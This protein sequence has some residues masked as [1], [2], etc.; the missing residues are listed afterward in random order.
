M[1]NKENCLTIFDSKVLSIKQIEEII[2]TTSERVVKS[3][4]I[5]IIENKSNRDLSGL[6]VLMKM[7]EHLE[8]DEIPQLEISNRFSKPKTDEIN[9][10]L[11]TSSL[12]VFSE[13]KSIADNII[14][15]SNLLIQKNNLV[16]FRH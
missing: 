4:S 16:R 6:L 2:L 15:A 10:Y 1:L 12:G 5:I 13:N 7:N 8:D 9:N 3:N 11:V 14:N